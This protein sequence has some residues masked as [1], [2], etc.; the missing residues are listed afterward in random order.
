MTKPGEGH[1]TEAVALCKEGSQS[2]TPCRDRNADLTLLPSSHLLPRSSISQSQVEAGRQG[3]PSLQVEKDGERSRAQ[4]CGITPPMMLRLAHQRAG[5]AW[6]T[7]LMGLTQW[8]SA[9]G[10]FPHQG[11]FGTVCRQFGFSQFGEGGKGLLASSGL[12]LRILRNLPKG[13]R[14]PPHRKEEFSSPGC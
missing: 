11:T 8:F 6:A 3:C 1:L 5:Q 12:R 14:Q 10:N 2:P 9:G 13:T 7:Q 4:D